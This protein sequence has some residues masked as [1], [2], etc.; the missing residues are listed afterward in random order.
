MSGLIKFI[1]LAWIINKFFRIIFSFFRKP[2][3][4]TPENKPTKSRRNM[5]IQDAEFEDVE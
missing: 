1:I 2:K 4:T 5:D 3:E